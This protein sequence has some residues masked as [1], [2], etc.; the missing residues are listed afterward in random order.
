M[1][2]IRADAGKE[3]G[4]GHIM[5]C[6]SV[7]DALRQLGCEVCFLTADESPLSLL[8]SRGHNYR[9]LGSS[10][11]N[12]ETE[13]QLLD[14]LFVRESRDLFLADSYY[15]TE[16]Y[17]RHI[18]N[19]M[20]VCYIDDM[21]RQNLP[22]DVL[23]NYN[24]FADAALYG[25]EGNNRGTI[26]LL[27][28][29]YAPLRREYQDTVYHVRRHADRVMI[30][31]GGSDRYNLAEKILR[32]A[33]EDPA[34]AQMEYCVVSGTYNEHLPQ[35]K[36]LEEN[37]RNVHVYS[38]V[39]R[40]WELMRECDVAVSAGGSTMYE[41][42]AAGVPMIGFSFVDNQERIVEG[43]LQKEMMCYGGNYLTEGDGM[44]ERI[45]HHMVL[46]MSDFRLRDRYSRRQRRLIDGKGAWRIG[47]ELCSFLE[48]QIGRV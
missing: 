27:G 28:V 15:L 25:L 45:V 21:C 33:L 48:N 23:I 34:G 35:L 12:P 5:R 18:R 4:S 47:H 19:Y 17:L 11:R 40:M 20:P 1:I 8:E 3:I 41:L 44:L 13:L 31:T 30:T 43:F 6:L 9:V 36:L 42:S 24:I 39:K 22:V 37:H 14:R 2:W 7:A 10:W 26:Y 38:D 46:L 16:E 29:E 32:L